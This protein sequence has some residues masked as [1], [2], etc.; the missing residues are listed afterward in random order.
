[1][2]E[3][4]LSQ[5]LAP[6]PEPSGLELDSRELASAAPNLAGP[7]IRRRPNRGSVPLSF[8]QRQVWLHGQFAP[9][10][11]LYNEVLI[12]ERRGALNKE[13]LERSFNEII[14]RHETLRTTFA[15][16]E[17]TPV[18]IISE[19]A[20]VELPLAEL[21]GLTE[22]QRE[23]EVLRLVRQEAQRPFDLAQ[24]P[25]LRFRLLR[26]ASENYILAVTL[27]TIV[28]DEWSLNILADELTALYQSYSAG[29]SSPLPD[30]P[31]QYEDYVR[32]QSS[33]GQSR[34]GEFQVSYWRERLAG[35][36]PVM[37]LPTDRPRPPVQRFH[38]ARHWHAITT[39]LSD[40]LGELSEQA[41][42]TLFE[43]LL[44][45]FQVLLFRYTAQ[46]DCVVGSIFSGRD[47]AETESLIGL[48]ASTAVIRT[49][50]GGDPTFQELLERVREAVRG[51]RKHQNVPFDRLVD[52]LQPE[53]DASRNPLFQVLFSLGTSLPRLRAGWELAKLA[54]DTGT[55]KVDLQLHLSTRPEGILASFTY[56]TDLFDAATI[57]RRAGHFE[58]LLESI[59]VNADQR[60]SALSVLT[61]AERQQLLVD[62]NATEADYR[63][64]L[65][66]HQLFEAQARRTPDAT[67]V[68]FENRHLTYAELNRRANQ[69]A[70]Y[71]RNLGVGPDILVGIEVERSLEMIVGLLGILK[72]G[73]AYVPLD[74]AF[75]HD[76]LAFMLE[77][78]EA[79]VLLTQQGL[80]E[81]LP[82]SSAKVVCLDTGWREIAQESTENPAATA[83]PEDLAY[84]IYT[85]G[86]TG[87]PKGVQVLHRGV[88]NFLTSMA[89]RP[90]MTARDR[91]LS[92]TTLSFDIAGLEIYLP[93]SLGASCEIVSREVAADGNQL[94]A[95]LANSGATVMQ[96]TPATWRML[97]E[98][99]W[100]GD[101]RLKILCG[102]EAVSQKLANQLLER[103][104]S[105]W[106]M[107]GPT[108]TT[109]WSTVSRI[110]A[111]QG[112][113]RIGRPIANTQI[114]ILDKVLQPVPIGVAG[115]LHIGG[116]GLARG[117]LKR[118]ELT[119][120]RF[121]AHP[122][123]EDPE[124][125]LYKTGDLVRYVP[126]GDIEF[127]GRLDHQVKIRGFRIELGEI[128]AALRQHPAVNE[129]VVIDR[130]DSPGDKRLVAY[131]VPGQEAAPVTSEL[132][133]FL[134][135]KLPEY[136]LPSAFVTLQKMPLTP[137]GKVNRRALP[138][139][140]KSDLA[141]KAAFAPPQ[142]A[143]ESELVKIWEETL[144]IQ[145]IGVR[146]DF[147]ELGG[148]SLLAVRIMHRVAQVFGRKI[149]VATLFQAP[150]VE[151]LAAIIQEQGWSPQWSSLVPIQV[152]D[153]RPPFFC[154]HGAGGVIIRFY[155]LARHLGS[156]Q[157]VYGLQARGLDEN[158]P[159][160]TRVEDMAAHYI[161]EMR[162][163]QPRGPYY[164]GGY[165]FGGVVALEIAQQLKAEGEET[166]VV[167]LFDTFSPAHKDGVSGNG[168]TDLG[169]KVSSALLDL[170]RSPQKGSQVRETARLFRKGI[171][172]RWS[173]MTV[174]RRLK[175]VR[176]ACEQ[177]ARE[178][179]PQTYS[180]RV[181]LFRSSPHLRLGDPY[182]EWNRYIVGGLEV[183]EVHGDHDN[184]LLE[185]QVRSVA[186]Q[187]R[188]CLHELQGRVQTVEAVNS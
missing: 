47:R 176:K 63:R 184:V 75:P 187:L 15:A 172:R 102:G 2:N 109:I 171:H 149:P 30:L 31:M 154:V 12:L 115:E 108:E 188:P 93:L 131:L 121:I 55:A 106:N 122:F 88:V 186:E 68:V 128:E 71:L 160:H 153:S 125:R 175:I 126:N 142:N 23:A 45:A 53:R 117:Y 134:K 90:G 156:E 37:E 56:N 59:V 86:S 94:L 130:E 140:E 136:M 69:L 114:Y 97:L 103:A 151:R 116:D 58:T 46:D 49:N 132:R 178:Y 22:A 144:R 119:A 185:P 148:H 157:P 43:F 77:D 78:A 96:A 139:P 14:R 26:L 18:Q 34:D 76:R 100:Q 51:A 82:E 10:V 101:P 70:H 7:P 143:T 28:A 39:N 66:V 80:V 73:G 169:Q 89:Q 129:T 107:Y 141:P 137:N 113:I 38:G 48:F 81:S 32:W 50:I 147:F 173:H 21:S 35:I 62:W 127:L 41:G 99:G 183:H 11:P 20:I 17:A 135:E 9:G 85:S 91:V 29:E 170:W 87:K 179:V 168:A 124:A 165:S 33:A 118:P 84:V 74:P 146:D 166:A 13:A 123:S 158:Y 163:V 40:S 83:K 174:P 61:R 36:P 120:D 161:T 105:L 1:M 112:A 67:A 180:G 111:G 162:S 52:E 98:A 60:I 27:H 24:G 95:K 3:L 152:G 19:P 42:V 92:V 4:N 150:S 6:I 159:C 65:C 104:G 145:P 133:A 64:D 155:D 110:E 181:V 72:A 79:P 16:E 167:V 54:V 8:A 177:A 57:S 164:V 5:P 44:A 138:P 25:L 182:Q